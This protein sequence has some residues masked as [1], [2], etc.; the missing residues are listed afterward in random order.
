MKHTHRWNLEDPQFRLMVQELKEEIA[1][2]WGLVIP[3]DG[4][5]G[6]YSS[7]QLG[8]LG[9]ELKRRVEVVL[10]WQENGGSSGST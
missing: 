5:W 9:A 1:R 4:Y 7:Q 6:G 3:K 8:K 10:A 2:E